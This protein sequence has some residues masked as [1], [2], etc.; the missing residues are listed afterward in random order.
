MKECTV[1]DTVMVMVTAMDNPMVMV[2]VS[3]MATVTFSPMATVKSLVTVRP[4]VMVSM[5]M[6]M[7]HTDKDILMVDT[8]DMSMG[9]MLMDKGSRCMGT[10]MVMDTL[11]DMVQDMATD[12]CMVK[13]PS[14]AKDKLLDT[15]TDPSKDRLLDTV[16]DMETGKG[17]VLLLF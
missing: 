3:P 13:D 10:G 6:A 1:R 12:L 15:V 2:M 16:Q 14:M 4:T 9:S 17:T 7:H 11:K 5:T 8:T